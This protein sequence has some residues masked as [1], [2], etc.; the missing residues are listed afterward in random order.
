MKEPR[1]TVCFLCS[2]GCGLTINRG[3]NRIYYQPD[4]TD[5]LEYQQDNPLNKG[6]LCGKCNYLFELS[7]H[8]KRIQGP[9]L[10]TPSGYNEVSWREITAYITDRM[11]DIVRKHGPESIGIILSPRLTVEETEHALECAKAIG[12]AHVDCCSLEDASMLT[13]IRQNTLFRGRRPAIEDIEKTHIAFIIGDVFSVS[14]VLARH[15][16]KAK[17]EKRANKLIVLES[18]HSNTSWFADI[19]LCPHPGT[20]ALVIAGIVKHIFD[21]SEMPRDMAARKGI[22]EVVD[23]IEISDI[24][25][26]TGISSDTIRSAADMVLEGNPSLIALASGIGVYERQDLLTDFCGIFAEVTDSRFL[27]VFT[28][29]NAQGIHDLVA[30]FRQSAGMTA[31]EMI[32]AAETKN[33]KALLNFGVDIVGAFPGVKAA[34]AL[35]NLDF[36]CSTAIFPNNTT[37]I[38]HVILPA[39]PWSEKTGT[40]VTMFNEHIRFNAVSL[41]PAH[42][43]STGEILLLLLDVLKKEKISAKA[44]SFSKTVVREDNKLAA[45]IKDIKELIESISVPETNGSQKTLVLGVDFAHTGDG[46][47]TRNLS[48]PQRVCPEPVALIGEGEDEAGEIKKIRIRSHGHK[49]ILPIRVK[50]SIGRGIVIVP[51]HFPHIR[52]LLEW[53]MLSESGCL[54]VRPIQVTVDYLR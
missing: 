23:S 8:P 20:E 29:A 37:I 4:A 27:P 43:K 18:F 45:R 16:L 39:V 44:S 46:T 9:K 34:N 32:E 50:R 11:S 53:E 33:L 30:D 42:L 24:C 14:P 15:F 5:E 26:I 38:S 52:K 3:E 7:S 36:L 49:L 1:N 51:G 31:P 25:K 2:L 47:I 40:T 41:P 22:D 12:T 6:S 19:H 10:L 21:Q 13:R 48:W 17:Y 54:N 35:S 28:G